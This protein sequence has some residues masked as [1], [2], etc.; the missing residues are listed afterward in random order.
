MADSKEFNAIKKALAQRGYDA[1]LFWDKRVPEMREQLRRVSR[2]TA[3][4]CVI[5]DATPFDL[6]DNANLVIYRTSALRSRLQANERIMPFIWE[7]KARMPALAR[8][9]R[10]RVAFCGFTNSHPTRRQCVET[11]LRSEDV[12]CDFIRR[13]RFWAGRPLD[14]VVIKAFDANLAGSEFNLCVRGAGNWSMR[15]YQTLSAGRIPVLLNTD[16]KLPLDD[17]DCIDWSDVC[18]VCRDAASM[19]QAI[20]SFWQSRDIEAA[21]QRCYEVYDKYFANCEW[22]KYH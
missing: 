15:F 3:A 19:P 7:A 8:A 13:D 17:A 18:V 1:V 5:D 14:P 9:E 2:P 10:P 22:L 20:L 6:E 4:V 16:V 12:K 11:L 21:Q